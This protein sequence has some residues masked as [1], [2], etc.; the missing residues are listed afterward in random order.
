MGERHQNSWMGAGQADM[1]TDDKIDE[2][3]QS[4]SQSAEAES[5]SDRL[6][7]ILAAEQHQTV[8]HETETDIWDGTSEGYQQALARGGGRFHFQRRILRCGSSR[9]RLLR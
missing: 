3:N 2:N 1:Q 9:T 6:V 4:Y 8:V 5:Y 7:D